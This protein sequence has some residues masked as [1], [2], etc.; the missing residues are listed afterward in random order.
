MAFDIRKIRADFPILSQEVNGKPLVYFDNAAT[1]QKPLAVIDAEAGVYKTINSNIHRGVHHLSNVC[2]EAFEDARKKVAGFI[3]ADSSDEIIFTRGTTE[4]V[5]LLSFSFGETFLKEGDEVILTEM[6]HHSNIVPWQLLAQRRGVAIKVVPVTD[7]GELDMQVFGELLNEKTRLVAVAHISNVMGTINPVEEI[8][9][10]AHAADVPVM[11]DGAQAI[12]HLPVDVQK[13]NSDFYVF[14]GHK[15]YAPTGVGVLYGKRKWLE[16]MKPYQGG[17]EMI[18]KVSF[19]GTTFNDLPYKFE[20]GTPNYAGVIG[21]GAAIDYLQ[22]QGLEEIWAYEHELFEYAKEKMQTVPGMRF[23]GQTANHT[24]VISFLL[25]HSHPFDVGTLLD[26]LGFA[27]RTGHHCA[28]PLM[29]RFQIS[30]TVRASFAF[31]NTKEEVD[32]LVEALL[33]VGSMLS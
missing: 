24:S 18:D 32:R 31:Y 26:K 7:N 28:Q 17:G 6:E 5:N 30:G 12:H 15:M 16:M 1:T 13:L 29:D 4:S 19:S 3:N 20:A 25:G 10:L 8:I 23:V 21:L 9:A 11:I 2:T 14:S 33:R 22:E 27:L